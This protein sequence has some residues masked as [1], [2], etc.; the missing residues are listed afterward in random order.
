MA[1]GVIHK[2]GIIARRSA[3]GYSRLGYYF[4]N[5]I[6][7]CCPERRYLWIWKPWLGADVYDQYARAVA[8]Q[9]RRVPCI[10]S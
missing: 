8:A 7:Q 1:R 10:E 2:G 9:V 6:S 5:R 3:D 4:V